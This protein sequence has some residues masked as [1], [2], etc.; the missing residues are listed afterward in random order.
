MAQ[1][2]LVTKDDLEQFKLDLIREITALLKPQQHDPKQWLRSV[3]VRKLLHI[4]PGTLQNFR[5]NGT[6]KF[7]KVGGIFYYKYDDILKVLEKKA[8]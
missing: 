5:V 2:D 3:E 8:R 7:T 4:S 6:L 1:I